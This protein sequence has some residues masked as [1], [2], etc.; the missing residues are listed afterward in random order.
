[1]DA[2]AS[3]ACRISDFFACEHSGMA[4]QEKPLS[5]PAPLRALHWLM[6]VVIFT[7]IGL[8]ITVINLPRGPLRIELVELHKSFGL[9]A[10]A[11]V[12]LRVVVRL[13]SRTP[14]YRPALGRLNSMA[15]HAVHGLLYVLMIVLPVSGYV[16]SMAGKHGFKWFGL[17]PVPNIVPPN[18]AADVGA[19][20]AHYL[21]AIG[22]GALL[23]AHVLAVI[24]HAGVKR[25][26][27]LARMWP[28]AAVK[29]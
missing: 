6:A 8:G 20:N 24:W 9:T 4:N 5:Y 18:E 17:F 19:G 10:L 2:D 16:H 12:V 26:G 15:A 11:L 28:Q 27:V 13:L 25:D 1:V 22:I 3:R 23:T 7:A 21:F 14:P 29:G